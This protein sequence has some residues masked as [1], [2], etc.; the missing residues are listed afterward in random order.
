MEICGLI[1]YAILAIPKVVGMAV[2]ELVSWKTDGIDRQVIGIG[3]AVGLFAL[4][5]LGLGLSE[6]TFERLEGTYL[7]VTSLLV[8][9]FGIL[10]AAIG[11]QWNNRWLGMLFFAIIGSFLVVLFGLV[12]S[13]R[14]FFDCLFCM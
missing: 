8:I 12:S 13:M 2:K 3:T 7:L 4:I 14:G 1:I 11:K 6:P 5:P 10:G 9:I